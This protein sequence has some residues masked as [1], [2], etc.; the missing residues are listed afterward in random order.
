MTKQSSLR[1]D[2]N[3]MAEETAV[4][5]GF[6]RDSGNWGSVS[7]T[8][9]IGT[10]D[11][12]TNVRKGV[13]YDTATGLTTIKSQAGGTNPTG[14]ASFDTTDSPGRWLQIL[15]GSKYLINTC[16]STTVIT[17]HGD[18]TQDFDNIADTTDVTAYELDITA[19]MNLLDELANNAYRK[20]L[21]AHD[22]HFLKPTQAFV[23]WA[24]VAV[25][26]GTTITGAEIGPAADDF[27]EV[28][29]SAA[30]FHETMEGKSLVSTGDGTFTIAKYISTTVVH[31]LN[32][33]STAI[34]SSTETTFC[35]GA[36]DSFT[37]I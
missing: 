10:D 27:M 3:L 24:D 36:L 12:N 26:A 21:S 31:I 11:T 2:Y 16:T 25:A 5:L 14:T 23:L 37:A 17:V 7:A 20:V 4:F 34:S 9:T 30:S 19:K 32:T 28:T 6:G 13:T 35:P 29:A 33:A 1:V 8:H 15:G 22:W 18:A